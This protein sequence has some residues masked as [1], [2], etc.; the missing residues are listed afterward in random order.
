MVRSLLFFS[1]TSSDGKKD[2]PYTM[3]LS[4]TNTLLP[5]VRRTLLKASEPPVIFIL[6]E[7]STLSFVPA[8]Y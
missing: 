8:V 7:I 1:E 6:Y 3:S 4:N 2:L 5:A